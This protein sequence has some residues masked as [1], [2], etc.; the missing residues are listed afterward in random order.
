MKTSNWYFADLNRWVD[1]PY[2]QIEYDI[3]ALKVGLN[4]VRLQNCATWKS[5][6]T[7]YIRR[8]SESGKIGY[9]TFMIPPMGA[10]VTLKSNISLNSEEYVLNEELDKIYIPIRVNA[11]LDNLNE[12]TKKEHIKN[13][14]IKLYINSKEVLDNSGSKITSLGNEYMLVLT[15]QDFP[16]SQKY[17]IEIKLDS[18]VQTAFANDGLLKTSEIKKIS[19]IVEDKKID[20]ITSSDIRELLSLDDKWVV[21]PLA[22]NYETKLENS[23]GFTESGRYIV[24]KNVLNMQENIDIN[25]IL[26]LQIYLNDIN[27][28]EYELL[29]YNNH[30]LNIKLKVPYEIDNTLYGYKSLR[31][32]N[33]SY[34]NIATSD[35]GSRKFKPY[36]LRLMYKYEGKEYENNM[37]LDILDDYVSN[38]NLYILDSY[39]VGKLQDLD[40]WLKS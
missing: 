4:K 29:N 32:K 5:S 40:K 15:R 25:K 38:M 19:L 14:N 2:N 8:L 3:N 18:L 7:V 27:L 9:A 11:H 24:I 23:C 35:V 26:G 20:V 12:Y 21:S 6:G 33:M 34:F 37:L 10:E 30:S 1:D 17:T 36:K 22:Q 28:S 16:Q 31:D 39:K 13:F